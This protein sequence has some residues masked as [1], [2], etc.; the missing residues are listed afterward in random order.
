MIRISPVPPAST[1]PSLSNL[2]DSLSLSSYSL[3]RDTLTLRLNLLKE[4]KSDQILSVRMALINTSTGVPML[5]SNNVQL[6]PYDS[7]YYNIYDAQ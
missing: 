6:I 5:D 7:T 4:V 2:Q 1:V 3:N